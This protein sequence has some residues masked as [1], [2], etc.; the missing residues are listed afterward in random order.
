MSVFH[1]NALIGSGGGAAAA[2]AAVAT[3]SLRF[4][5]GDGAYLSRTP[6]STGNR[7]TFTLS[8]WVKRHRLD[9]N[10]QQ[11]FGQYR[12]GSPEAQNRFQFYFLGTGEL[13]IHTF[14]LTH[15]KTSRV[16]RDPGAWYHIVLAVDTTSSTADN[17]MRIYVN[18]A[19]VTD[20]A[21][22][23]NPSQN[24]D[25]G[26]NTDGEI[27]IG[28]AANAKSSYYGDFSLAD[29]YFIEGS[30]LDATSFGAYDDSGVWQASGYSGTYG[31]NGFRLLD[32][33]NESTIG[34]DSSGNNNDFTANNLIFENPAPLPSVLFDGSGDYLSFAD[35][36]DFDLVSSG[37]GDFT[38]EFFIQ[39]TAS[40]N[41]Y[42][43]ASGT[44]ATRLYI[45]ASSGRIHLNNPTDSF[46]MESSA[47]YT[48][49][50][51]ATGWVHIAFVKSSSTGYVFV[52]GTSYAAHSGSFTLGGSLDFNN[53]TISRDSTGVQ[54]YI[55][56][57]RIVK[58]SA[59]Y[60]SNFAT[61][62]APLSN[63]TNTKL[64]CCQSSS[65]TTA[66]TVTPGTIT[67]NGDVAASSVAANS[68]GANDVLFDVP[69]NDTTNTD[70]A[71]GGEVSGNYA[72]FN[73]L[74]TTNT[75]GLANG[76][77]QQSGL[78]NSHATIRIPSTGK[79]YF[80][81]TPTQK[82][83]GYVMGIQALATPASPSNSNTMGVDEGGN[84]Y[85]GN[86][87]T[88]SSFLSAI[89]VGDTLGVAIDKDGNTL[90]FLR[91][92]VAGGS[93]L[94]P[95][96]LGSD[97]V[98]FI[99]TNSATVDV[100]FGQ[101]PFGYSLV[102]SSLV[103]GPIAG[104]PNDATKMFDGSTS[105]FTDHSSTNSTIKYSNTL[106]GVT[107][108]KVY[109]HQ[110]NSTGTVTT[111]GANGTQTDTI[112]ADFGPAYHTISLS[113]TGST[114]HSIAFTRGGSGNFL[115][116]YAIEVNGVVL[117]DSTATGFKTLNTS[118]LPTPTI[119]DGSDY[120][121]A[122][123]YTGN[124]GT[125]TITGL[126]FSPDWVWI[127]NRVDATSHMLFDIVRGV[128]KV[129]YSNAT[130]E[131]QPASISVTAFNSDGF[132]VGSANEVNGNNDAMVAWCWD[133]G[134]STVS[135][136]D[137]SITSN[138][139]ANQSA[140][141]S[142][143][144]FTG[145]GSAA[146]IGHGLNAE[147]YLLLTKCRESGF[148]WAVYHKSTGNTGR[149]LLNNTFAFETGSGVGM[150]NNTTPTNSVFSVGSF[151]AS[152]NTFVA[153]C[154]APVAGYSAF[155][156]YTG[157]GS[158]DGTFVH[159]GMRPAWIL[160]RSTSSNRGWVIWD[161]SR[162]PY[163]V[164]DANLFPNNNSAESSS[165]DHNIDILSNGF[166]LRT[167]SA[168]RNGSGETYIYA[169]FSENAFSLNGGLAR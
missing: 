38:I 46:L 91:N 108:L 141:F 168:N 98:P 99:H 78:T 102:Q 13:E 27:N 33:A 4:N 66:A 167:T 19:E 101:R 67:A 71:A 159:T 29:I 49:Y 39:R 11:I 34:H 113:S 35:S 55:S 94:T 147:P 12:A 122:K 51:N 127:K 52:N 133:G 86:G 121:E 47:A 5:S 129:I 68:T 162:D 36:S 23:N 105:T 37:T 152:G 9:G 17:R 43:L 65:S 48:A 115:S 137:G 146:T 15:L 53:L 80:E 163:N 62:N 132:T 42:V 118:S 31:T 131:E 69:T 107:S 160:V 30:Q 81:F 111:V 75:G 128:Q 148:N 124:G 90:S 100:N 140:G 116:I 106:T 20:F 28:T 32:F 73:R 72:T 3:K 149:L 83:A 54:G 59:V 79:W 125:N 154:F 14:S 57:L 6:S 93:T 119:P 96:S 134:S 70:S 136:T 58:G 26:V 153:Y 103:S 50:N 41:M 64:L 63:V 114:I 126:E 150:W 10:A 21:T 8:L 144:T 117:T 143:V 18:G 123:L 139:R 120:F 109:I 24:L 142:I 130:T 158:T 135:N 61:P 84:R 60:T 112:S 169:A 156:S 16:F 74:S 138:V 89:G 110:G 164:A 2:D 85:N 77:L 165:S 151:F 88:T 155:G 56:N 22:R 97:V 145:T 87:S 40:A 45:N 44:D 95:S 1:N 76:N 161:T 104:S 92:G 82:T 157:N 25:L 166:K 7:K